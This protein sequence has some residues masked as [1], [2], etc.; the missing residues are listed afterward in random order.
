MS[1]VYFHLHTNPTYIAVEEFLWNNVSK[2]LYSSLCQSQE[3][4]KNKTS[5]NKNWFSNSESAFF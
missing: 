2:T 5:N 1:I 4:Y 3:A